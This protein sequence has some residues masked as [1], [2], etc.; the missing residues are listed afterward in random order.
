MAWLKQ[1]TRNP[2]TKKQHKYPDSHTMKIT[3][4]EPQAKNK[5]RVSVYL[6]GEFAFGIHSDV[7]IKSGIG[8]GDEI[9]AQKIADILSLENRKAAMEKAYRL[10][11]VRARSEKELKDRLRGEKYSDD[12]IAWVL[13]ELM[14][15]GLIDDKSFAIQ[16]S[17]SRV[18][19][20]PVGAFYLRQE[21]KQKGLAE[22]HIETG[23]EEAFKEKS[24]VNMAMDL[25]KKKKSQMTSVE[26]LRAK[27]KLS[28]FLL[29]RG[30]GWEIV[31]D[32][33]DQWEQL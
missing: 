15:L 3:L 21:L 24:E 32:I 10:L 11:A 14:R 5:N 33:L 28:D 26:E 2:K 25:A 12:A 6:D 8:K 19:L 30:F 1:K 31:N 7:L 22:N 18:S 29:R 9:S 23:I 16:F 4:I 17:K 13:Q 20:K 27:K